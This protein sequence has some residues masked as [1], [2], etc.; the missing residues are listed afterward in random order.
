MKKI[1]SIVLVLAMAFSIC[2]VTGCGK[3]DSAE[4]SSDLQYIQDKGTL[5]VGITDFA[6]MD[7]KENKDSEDW[8]GFDADMAKA[9][10]DSLGVNV[11]F[12]EINWD[13]KITEL[14]NKGIDCVWNGMT[15]NDEVK[16]GMAVS[17]AYCKNA[18]VVVVKKDV[19]DKYQ[20]VDSIKD[21]Q[22][23]VE[24]GSAGQEQAEAYGLNFIGAEAQS[25][26]L[27]E[28]SAGT[29]DAAIIDLLMAG[30]MIGE[31]TDYA[32][33]AYTVELNSEEYGVGFRKGS[34]VV[35]KI[36]EFFKTAYND[37][38]M[39]KIAEKY[40]VQESLIEQK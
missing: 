9:F 18:Q 14:D 26:T 13:Y 36:N 17:N 38:S 34:D 10:A 28:V 24:A 21:L 15:L 40:G 31:G 20:T 4:T 19:A 12:K 3:D 39:L 22:F 25:S 8:I 11:E 5:V 2:M 7:Y 29:S 30:A 33:L 1:L 16:A 35:D 23:A 37:G 27:M 6:P 32:G